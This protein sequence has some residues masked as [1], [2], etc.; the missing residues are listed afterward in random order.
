MTTDI[1]ALADTVPD[2]T[3]RAEPLMPGVTYRRVLVIR[4]ATRR[5]TKHAPTPDTNA[6]VAEFLARGGRVTRCPTRFAAPSAGGL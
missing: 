4:Y 1:D 3:P 5:F 6:A 2:L